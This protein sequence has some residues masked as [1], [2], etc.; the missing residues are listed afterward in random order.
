MHRPGLEDA[1]LAGEGPRG[2]VLSDLRAAAIQAIV[3][4]CLAHRLEGE[5]YADCLT[6]IGAH[7]YAAMLQAALA[8]EPPATSFRG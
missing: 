4:L 3:D 7:K 5:R 1:L 6:R 2:D 8:G